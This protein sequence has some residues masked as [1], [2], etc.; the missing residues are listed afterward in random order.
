MRLPDFIRNFLADPPPDYV[1]EISAGGVA[2]ARGSGDEAGFEPLDADVLDIS[3]M[4]D[5]LLK[6]EAL[7][8]VARKLFGESS[9]KKARKTAALIL[10]DYCARI[11]VLDFDAFPAKPEE[12]LALVKFRMKKSVPFDVDAAV[13]SYFA[14]PRHDAPKK[15]DVVVTVAALEIVSRYEAPFRAAG[16][17]V[18]LV[19]VSSLAMADLLPQ[20]QTVACAKL[21]GRVMSLTIA[22]HGAIK[23]VRCVELPS[24]TEDDISSVLYPTFAYMEDELK[25]RPQ[26]LFLA[27]FGDWAIYVGPRVEAELRVVAEQLPSR[28]G[29]PD[30]QNA[31]LLG[32]LEARR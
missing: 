31:G 11:A 17:D 19:T 16:F 26:R 22:S 6:P 9:S 12:Q 4:S 30:A 24:L 15:F 7:E 29:Q 8:E 25:A 32:Y 2:W 14:Q 3:P 13:V 21:S 23:M 20:V 1:F 27:G 10:P 18:G 28:F 5:N